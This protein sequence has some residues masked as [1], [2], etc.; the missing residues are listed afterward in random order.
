[1]GKVNYSMKDNNR[2]PDI[3]TRKGIG[4]FSIK[5]IEFESSFEII[6]YPQKTIIE[7]QIADNYISNKL[8]ATHD[9]F[10]ELKGVTE[11]NI[12]VFAKNLM[13]VNIVGNQLTLFSFKDL[14]FGENEITNFSSAEFPLVGIYD[15]DFNFENN[16][17]EISCHGQK[18]KL[19]I[20]REKSKNWNIQLE[21]NIL[22]LK[23]ANTTKDQFLTRANNITS[24][25]SLALG[26]DVVFNRQ[27]Y[28]KDEKLVFEE[29][30]R[31][32]DY[33]FGTERC[34][35]DFELSDFIKLTID[36]YEKWDEK[37]IKLFFS[38]VTYINSSSKGYL[39]N[40][41]LG[42][43]IAW[44][45]LAQSWVS[46]KNDFS[47]TDLDPFK[48]FLKQTISNFELPVRYEKDFIKE[49]ILKSLEWEKLTESLMSLSDQF[50]LDQVK[51]GLDF[52]SLIKIRNDIAHT[53]LLRKKY[54]QEFLSDL[55]Y[56]HK[57]GL[58]VI[59]LLELG[60]D[61][62]IESQKDKWRTFI[63]IEEL[64]KPSP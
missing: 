39:E 18:D 30:R 15:Q 16:N 24:L 57:L 4:T 43:S 47:N 60:Y 33:H 35:P 13:S 51:L 50:K 26:N 56:N 6:H 54:A 45:S 17:W 21:G 27:F 49:R 62:L 23:K 64:Q 3:I 48:N 52:K 58:Q 28:F 1:M 14:S 32:V 22:R 29:W 38:T 10:W 41:L 40:R 12:S 34:I 20:L 37:K 44:E 36:N 7:T 59:L 2:Y 42:I 25:L 8:L 63:K 46:K 53:G 61:K 5:K 9:E 55:I 11:D 31:K 19:E